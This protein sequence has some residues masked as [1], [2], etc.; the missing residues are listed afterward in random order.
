MKNPIKRLILPICGLL[1]LLFVSGCIEERR[2]S[3][4]SSGYSRPAY[5]S[6]PVRRTYRSG[7]YSS[8]YRSPYYNNSRYYGGTRYRSSRSPYY[9]NN[10]RSTRPRVHVSF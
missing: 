10:S 3:R 7:Y 8:G 5:Y 2:Y 9:Y 6:T 1:C 4:S